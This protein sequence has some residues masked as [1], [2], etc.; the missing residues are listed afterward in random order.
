MKAKTKLT[1]IYAIVPIQN[2]KPRFDFKFRIPFDFV[3]IIA[4]HKKPKEYRPFATIPHAIMPKISVTVK[5]KRLN[6]IV[7]VRPAS[8]TRILK[9]SLFLFQYV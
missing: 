7:E 3:I 6:K 2:K 5:D 9:S 1:N 4:S 8:P